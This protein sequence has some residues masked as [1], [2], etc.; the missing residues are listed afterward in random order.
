M[1]CKNRINKEICKAS[2]ATPYDEIFDCKTKRKECPEFKVN[3]E[4]GG[5]YD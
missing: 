2:W 4:K 5:S 1:K 3:D